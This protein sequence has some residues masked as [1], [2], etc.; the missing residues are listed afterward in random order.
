[1]EKKILILARFLKFNLQAWR[2]TE[3]SLECDQKKC[4]P[5][6]NDLTEVGAG[7]GETES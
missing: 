7:R 6:I 3:C 2:I 1:M 4:K 5:Y